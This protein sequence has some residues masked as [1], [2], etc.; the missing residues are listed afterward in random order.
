M[1]MLLSRP[2][3]HMP[4]F[5]EG[6][7]I[8]SPML[9]RN[10]LRGHV[11]LVDFWDYSC[12]NCIRTLPHV[13]SW[14]RRYE[15]QGLQIIGVHTPEFKFARQR[16]QVEAAMEEFNLSYPVLLDN[17]YE[18]WELYANK[19]W[20]TK[21][22]I[23]ANGYIRYERRG[24]GGYQN[25][26]LAIQKLLV[27]R[28]PRV[29]LPDIR[30]L[31]REEDPVGAACYPSTP[32]LH[33]GFAAGLFGGSLGNPEGYLPQEAVVYDL[34]PGREE[35]AFYLEGIWQ[36]GRESLNFAGHDRGR[37]L[38]PYSA[39][40]VNAVLSPS[41]D[42]VELMLGILP[43]RDEP[44]VEVRLNGRPLPPGDAGRDICF[45]RDGRSLVQVTRPRLYE[46]VDHPDFQSN[47]LELIFLTHGLALFT[48][49]F[50]TCIVPIGPD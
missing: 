49:T 10:S 34:P 19:A 16:H 20:P 43:A 1:L 44:M 42:E 28:D 50:T 26:E 32:E 48:L 33:A 46:L 29:K 35:G 14:H 17:H 39:A 8:N 23:D 31:F 47:E 37:I 5:G 41:G 45:D 13:A 27:E 7:W 11:I 2:V 15:A 6:D 36:A 38:V 25:T 40:G 3:V 30:P 4:E 22:L 12:V 9:S 21:Y 18:N 24:E